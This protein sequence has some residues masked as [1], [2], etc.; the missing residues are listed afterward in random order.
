MHRP[1][2][3]LAISLSQVRRANHYTTETSCTAGENHCTGVAGAW[4]M[5][6]PDER[7]LVIIIIIII[8]IND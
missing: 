4:C 7:F 5:F 6:A 8:I 1:G 3:E 2:V